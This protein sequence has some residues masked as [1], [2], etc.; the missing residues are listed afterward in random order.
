MIAL[1]EGCCFNKEATQT[2]IHRV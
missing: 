1:I 2:G